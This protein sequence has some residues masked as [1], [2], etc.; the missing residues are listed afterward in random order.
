MGKKDGKNYIIRN[1]GFILNYNSYEIDLTI[2]AKR[3]FLKASVN[4][5]YVVKEDGVKEIVFYIHKDLQVEKIICDMIVDFEVGEY[6]TEWSPFILESKKI[7]LQFDSSLI[8]DSVLDI[9]FQY[10]GNIHLV[11]QYEINRITEDWLELGIYTPWYPL[12]E[13]MN[14]SLFKV[15]IKIDPDYKILSNGGVTRYDKNWII[16]QDQPS[17]DCVIIGSNNFKYSIDGENQSNI[18][19][20]YIADDLEEVANRINSQASC[21][22]K[23][24]S[25]LF[26]HVKNDGFD[27]FIAPRHDG[28]GYCRDK[29]IV[30][31]TSTD[32][33]IEDSIKDASLEQQIKT[34]RFIA[35]ELSH[36][37][38]FKAEPTS[39][40]DWLNESFAEYSSLMAT[41]EQYGEKEFLRL[42]NLYKEKTSNSPAIRGINR[43]DQEAFNVLYAKGPTILNQLEM[44]IGE[45]SFKELLKNTH[46][47]KINKTIDF[48]NEL[49]FLTNKKT[50]EEFSKLLDL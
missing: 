36:L 49:T 50:S 21:L 12:S 30:L 46:K 44:M 31:T 29:L 7:T 48:L 4:M 2:E 3:S 9:S 27:I 10:S 20:Y 42:I 24:F 43:S 16:V 45:E 13:Q 1:G 5:K 6:I 8:K 25:R 33:S 35:H 32:G 11:T 26:G 47:K 40:E 14:H 39:W 28:G 38:W 41:R 17:L 37:W 19:T 34:F 23:K 15:N 22:F 18:K